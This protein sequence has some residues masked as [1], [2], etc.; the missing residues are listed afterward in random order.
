MKRTAHE[1]SLTKDTLNAL[2]TQIPSQDSTTDIMN[3][4]LVS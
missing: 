4:L 1:H 3:R 2:N